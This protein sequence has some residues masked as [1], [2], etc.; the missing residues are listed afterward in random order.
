MIP[1][2][3]QNVLG[4]SAK[5]TG[6]VVVPGAI[7]MAIM[8]TLSGVLSHRFG[9]RLFTVGGLASSATGL[10]ILSRLIENSSLWMVVPA[11]I[12]MNTGMGTFYSP[13]SSSVMN[14]VGQAKYGVVSGFL[15]LVR[16][17]ANVTSIA[18]ATIIVTTT[19]ASHGFE[20]TLEAV[21][22]DTVGV[23]HAFTLGLRY[24]FLSMMSILLLSMT[25]SALQPNR[26]VRPDAEPKKPDG[27]T[28]SQ[29]EV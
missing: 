2:Y 28:E 16:N 9:W 18:F 20:P 24:A 15:N 4:Y 5:M 17:A 13:N 8:G 27:L 3:L 22:G 14:A 7:C 25:L 10:L 11:L 26:V 23:S 1:F 12:L 29:T 21:R 19:M 6:F